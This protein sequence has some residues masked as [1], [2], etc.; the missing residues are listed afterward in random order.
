M[1]WDA[2]NWKE[3]QLITSRKTN[4]YNSNRSNSHNVVA[5]ESEG[6]R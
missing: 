4:N 5:A 2:E 1:Y 3:K 6:M